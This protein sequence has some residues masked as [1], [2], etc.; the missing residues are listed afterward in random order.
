M[1]SIAF[2]ILMIWIVYNYKV[3][4]LQTFEREITNTYVQIDTLIINTIDLNAKKIYRY[5]KYF[6]SVTK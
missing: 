5:N 2:F 4:C 3:Q 6:I 1:R